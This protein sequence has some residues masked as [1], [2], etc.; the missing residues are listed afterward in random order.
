MRRI[1][2]YW[3]PKSFRVLNCWLDDKRFPAHVEKVWSELAVQGWSASPILKEKLKGL[4]VNLKQWNKAVFGDLR[5][6]RNAAV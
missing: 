2:Q 5:D 1:F 6:N 3:G 4:K